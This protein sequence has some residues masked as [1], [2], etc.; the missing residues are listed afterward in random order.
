M[1]DLQPAPEATKTNHL[2]GSL[3]SLISI[4]VKGNYS[5]TKPFLFPTA[6]L[7]HR[8]GG[9]GDPQILIDEAFHS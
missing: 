7:G 3:G 6:D 8:A 9:G 5:E 1:P 4:N 2:L